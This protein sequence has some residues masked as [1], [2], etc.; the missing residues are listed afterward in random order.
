MPP[1]CYHLRSSK[2]MVCFKK[3]V[4]EKTLDPH[5]AEDFACLRGEYYRI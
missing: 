2:L 5:S 3:V 4:L 1:V